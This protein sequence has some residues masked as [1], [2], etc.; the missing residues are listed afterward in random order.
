VKARNGIVSANLFGG[1]MS[2]KTQFFTIKKIITIII[3]LGVFSINCSTTEKVLNNENSVVHKKQSIKMPKIFSPLFYADEFNGDNFLKTLKCREKSKNTFVFQEKTY[4][5]LRIEPSPFEFFNVY[6]ADT[7]SEITYDENNEVVS[8]EIDLYPPN[9]SEADLI[10]IFNK[11]KNVISSEYGKP[12]NVLML[13]AFGGNKEN[14]SISWNVGE[15]VL[16]VRHHPP[17]DDGWEIDINY[18]KKY[19]YKHYSY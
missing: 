7:V 19:L 15:Y 5:V 2:K 16:C 9:N 13:A 14:R 8:L 10:P 18:F 17:S 3:L 11:I 6:K 1:K 12:N 4:T